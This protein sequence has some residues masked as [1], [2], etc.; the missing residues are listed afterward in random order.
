M[1]ESNGG[2]VVTHPIPD[3]PWFGIDVGGTLVKLVYFEPLDL[4]PDE[5]IKEGDVLR[6]IRHYLIGNTAYGE[7]GIRDLHL[8]LKSIKI[9]NRLGNMHFIRFPSNQMELFIDLCVTRKLH[10]L[11]FQVYATGGGAFKFESVVSERLKIGWNKCD[12][13]DMLIQGVEF[14]NELNSTDECY[15][16]EIEPEEGAVPDV[17]YHNGEHE[18]ISPSSSS[19]SGEGVVGP[20]KPAPSAPVVVGT[21]SA[22]LSA[23]QSSSSLASSQSN[24]TTEYQTTSTTASHAASHCRYIKHSYPFANS[25]PYILVNIGSGVSILLVKS[26]KKYKRISGSSI[27]GGT[28]LGLCC[29]LTGCKTYEEAIELA[30]RG[31]STKVDKS[32]R[33]IY[34]GDY[35]KFGLP[36]D[37]VASS[38]GNMNIS[39]RRSTATREDLARATLQTVLNNIGLIARDCATNYECERVLFVGSFLRINDL[40]KHLLAY[41]TDYWSR[42]TIKALFLEH[43]GY[44]GAIGCLK[45]FIYN[46]P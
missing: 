40:S 22:S 25:Y 42:G 19:P 44:F 24:S 12:E 33:D 6:T 43:E 8:E 29:L 18:S 28:F 31:D 4:T 37:I 30:T 14:L 36:G 27:G 45:H 3:F 10:T 34:G 21:S 13:M 5:E 39:E 20:P 7:S 11:T 26:E 35:S 9:G 32:V 16:Y 41:A 23:S 2:E 15:Y 17:V 1:S 46:D 38:F